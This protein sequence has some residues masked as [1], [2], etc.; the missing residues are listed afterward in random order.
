MSSSNI[1]DSNTTTVM[2]PDMCYLCYSSTACY[3][4]QPSYYLTQT[5]LCVTSTTRI[6]TAQRVDNVTQMI[7][8]AG[9]SISA[10]CNLALDGNITVSFPFTTLGNVTV[11]Q[12]A[13]N[14]VMYVGD[15]AFNISGVALTYGAPIIT[16]AFDGSVPNRIA[17]VAY[18]NVDC[19]SS[20]GNSWA[21]AFFENR[22]TNFET[23]LNQVQAGAERNIEVISGNKSIY[24]IA[25]ANGSKY[26]LTTGYSCI[27]QNSSN[28]GVCDTS[29]TNCLACTNNYSLMENVCQQTCPSGYSSVNWKCVKNNVA[30]MPAPAQNNTN[31]IIMWVFIGLA[32]FLVVALVVVAIV[33]CLKEKKAE[34][35]KQID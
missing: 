22:T 32:I 12:I 11:V 21:A 19:M 16:F 27:V 17:T 23:A 24:K 5:L 34:T 10:S 25:V 31:K 20:Q 7:V 28:C 13:N 8:A 1:S 18:K 6:W 4:C 9:G 26:L 30:P 15:S 29:F 14:S 2:C 33:C 35:K 3:Q